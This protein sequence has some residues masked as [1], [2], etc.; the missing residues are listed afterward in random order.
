LILA[1]NQLSGPA[2]QLAEIQKNNIDSVKKKTLGS[3]IQQFT[4]NFNS[5]SEA[6]EELD[7]DDNIQEAYFSYRIHRES[8]SEYFENRKSKLTN[9][10]KERNDLVHHLL[11]KF[12]L[13]NESDLVKLAD[14]LDLQYEE[15]TVEKQ[16]LDSELN[17]L[18]QA[19]TYMTEFF[20]SPLFTNLIINP[21]L[22]SYLIQAIEKHS[23]IDGWTDLCHAGKIINKEMPDKY[24]ESLKSNKVRKL[25]AL[26]NTTGLF[27]IM[28]EEGD[29]CVI[30]SF[31]KPIDENLTKI[32]CGIWT[33]P[34]FSD[35]H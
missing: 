19:R 20:T 2:S 17:S 25:S 22:I 4:S 10:L 1:N 7:I 31:F 3:L 30:R 12:D 13:T 34:T 11:L 16:C 5:D 27:E 23:R 28:Q 26:I 15:A 32:W 35:T 29:N 14:K 6:S 9:I 24:R 18:Q 21:E 33:S 8:D